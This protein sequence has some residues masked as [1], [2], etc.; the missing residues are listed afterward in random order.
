MERCIHKHV[1]KY[2]IEHSVITPFQSG[3]RAGDST[4]NQLLYICNEISNALDNN[5]ELRIVFLDI[6]KAFDRVWHKGLLFK[7]KPVGIAGKLLDW[8]SNYLLDRY[9]HV[10]IRNVTSS[11]KKINAGVPNGSILG[12]LLFI[13]SINDIIKDINSFIRPFADDTCIFKTV[14]DPVASA[15]ILNDILKKILAW[16]KQ[17]LVLFNA[18][19]TKVL[20]AYKK[21]MK[22]YHP[23]LFKG[24]TQVKEVFKHKHLGLMISSD[25]SL[26][27]HIRIIQKKNGI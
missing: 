21:Q 26:N 11:W 18:L 7:L 3:F 8:L 20:L 6:S 19:K 5:K 1:S 13:I 14:D 9:Q 27:D 24:D 12:P 22:L 25:F 17:W 2:L 23:P 10:C 4:V 15:A 16:A